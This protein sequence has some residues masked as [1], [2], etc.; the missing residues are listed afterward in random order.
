MNQNF[1][2]LYVKTS[3]LLKKYL[4][5]SK[6][7]YSYNYLDLDLSRI[8]RLKK[9]MW[10][11]K[12]GET[13][14]TL[15]RTLFKR[16]IFLL[17]IQD[18]S[19][20]SLNQLNILNPSCIAARRQG[21]FKVWNSLPEIVDSSGNPQK[22]SVA[23]RPSPPPLELIAVGTLAVFCPWWHGLCVFPQSVFTVLFR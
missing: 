7:F 15:Y 23:L 18:S 17:W 14:I 12:P 2:C 13:E 1:S 9:I 5:L 16:W 20:H 19:T 8:L 21:L 3:F 6:I 4:N 22:K 10:V 11:M